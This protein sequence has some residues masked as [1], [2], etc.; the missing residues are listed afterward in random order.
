MPASGG[1]T[2]VTGRVLISRPAPP[3]PPYP[4]HLPLSSGAPPPYPPPPA[5][6]T[7]ILVQASPPPPPASPSLPP[8]RRQLLLHFSTF[9]PRSH[10]LS[11]SAVHTWSCC[12]FSLVLSLSFKPDFRIL[13][14]TWLSLSFRQKEYHFDA[15]YHPSL[16]LP[17]S[18]V[19]LTTYFLVSFPIPLRLTLTRFPSPFCIVR[20]ARCSAILNAR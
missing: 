18:W 14:S 13:I 2:S 9:T 5:T 12:S 8:P 6:T 10:F 7:T 11:V 1:R 17:H 3:P 19:S 20:A 15:F 4:S 16:H